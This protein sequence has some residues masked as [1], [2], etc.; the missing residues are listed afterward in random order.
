MDAAFLALAGAATALATGVGAVPVFLL[1]ERADRLRP[2][3][4]GTAVGLMGV[5]SVVGLLLPALD[6]DG[7]ATVAA[8]VLVGALFLLASRARW[9]LRGCGRD[10]RRRWGHAHARG[11]P[12]RGLSG[13]RLAAAR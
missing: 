2:F 5:A 3:L 7:G 9:P 4:W 12:R 13:L 10:R 8:G 6:E 1:G 11:V